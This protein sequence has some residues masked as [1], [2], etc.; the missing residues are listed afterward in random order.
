LIR[1]PSYSFLSHFYPNVDLPKEFEMPKSVLEARKEKRRLDALAK[2]ALF[3]DR[4][5]D[6][7]RYFYLE[8]E[9]LR[10]LRG[11]KEVTAD[12]IE[13]IHNQKAVNVEGLKLDHP[14]LK[15]AAE[16]AGPFEKVLREKELKSLCLIP[17]GTSLLNGYSY[18]KLSI[19]IPEKW[20]L[21]KQYFEDFGNEGDM[22]GFLTCY[23]DKVSEV[24]GIPIDGL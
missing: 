20:E 10:I 4:S 18:Y 17:A 13:I 7:I 19:E 5:V 23:P 8:N 16:V 15:L 6:S 24:L 3:I 2:D 11:E 1:N 22:T 21:V 14:F 12:K 9:E